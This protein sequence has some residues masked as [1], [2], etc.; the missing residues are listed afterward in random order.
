ME[1]HGFLHSITTGEQVIMIEITFKLTIHFL[2]LRK[3][4]INNNTHT[5]T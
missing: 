2:M 1:L 3:D 5:K 4:Y